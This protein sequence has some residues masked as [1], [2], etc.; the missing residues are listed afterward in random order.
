MSGVLHSVGRQLTFQ[1]VIG[2]LRKITTLRSQLWMASLTPVVLCF[3]TWQAISG[4][5]GTNW[6]EIWLQTL[7][8]AQ[9][10]FIVI[11]VNFFAAEF[12][13]GQLF[14]SLA[15]VPCRNKF[16]GGKALALLVWVTPLSF[17]TVVLSFTSAYLAARHVGTGIEMSTGMGRVLTGGHLLTMLGASVYFVLLSFL[18]ASLTVIF[19]QPLGLLASTITWTQLLS[20]LV[21]ENGLGL[22]KVAFLFPDLAGRATFDPQ[23]HDKIMQSLAVNWL[24]LLLWLSVLMF[25]AGAIFRRRDVT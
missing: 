17:L 12:T 2:E 5:Q 18:V 10:F 24:V 11:T 16:L 25:V 23:I 15:L 3:F 7:T 8:Y 9:I 21:L 1:V 20:P 22:K 6:V 4:G 14:A 19:R 13:S